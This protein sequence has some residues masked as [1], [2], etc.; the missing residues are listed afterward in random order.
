MKIEVPNQIQTNKWDYLVK[1]KGYVF[2]VE[3]QLDQ[4]EISSLTGTD[5]LKCNSVTSLEDLCKCVAQ[6]NKDP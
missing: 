4:T 6:I 2:G 1:E 5:P 3:M